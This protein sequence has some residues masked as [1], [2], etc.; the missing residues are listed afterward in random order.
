[1]TKKREFPPN[2]SPEIYESSRLETCPIWI[3][4]RVYEYWLARGM[5]AD[6]H[7]AF[8]T[9]GNHN[10]KEEFLT[11]IQTIPTLLPKAERQANRIKITEIK[12]SRD[13]EFE[14]FIKSMKEN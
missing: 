7:K 6:S 11:W 14:D 5:G 3:L 4:P 2:F 9:V 13:K 12:K 1:M 10:T 8:E